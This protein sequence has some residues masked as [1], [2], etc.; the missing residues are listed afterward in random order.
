MFGKYLIIIYN[1]FFQAEALKEVS[2]MIQ[3]ETGLLA[4]L[5][6]EKSKANEYKIAGKVMG[7]DEE[8]RFIQLLLPMMGSIM[9][10]G[11]MASTAKG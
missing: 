11:A 3:E 10:V 5:K 8:N 6:I 7:T 2:L 9:L 1:I 4:E